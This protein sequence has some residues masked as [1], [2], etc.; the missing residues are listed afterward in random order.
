MGFYPIGSHPVGYP[1]VAQGGCGSNE[2]VVPWT[3]G[4]WALV[5]MS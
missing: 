2:Q 1:K 4:R 5:C 3:L